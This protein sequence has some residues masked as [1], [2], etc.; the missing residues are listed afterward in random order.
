MHSP[1]TCQVPGNHVLL[2]RTPVHINAVSPTGRTRGAPGWSFNTKTAERTFLSR[3]RGARAAEKGRLT[4]VRSSTPGR[5]MSAPA[6]AAS[7]GEAREASASGKE[8]ITVFSD[9][10]SLR[11][12]LLGERGSSTEVSPPRRIPSNAKRGIR[13]DG[14][15]DVLTS[16]L[17]TRVRVG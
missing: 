3:R 2:K 11:C 12:S 5:S 10:A 15:D 17:L 16:Q 7:P 14:A 13:V 8:R 6:K 4:L 1:H 9:A